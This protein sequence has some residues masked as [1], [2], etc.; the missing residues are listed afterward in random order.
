MRKILCIILLCMSAFADKSLNI[1]V[2]SMHC[3]L[4]TSLVR[5]E[6]MKVDGVISV[7][8]SLQTKTA[9]V[10]ARDDVSESALLKAIADIQYPGVIQK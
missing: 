10:V 8:V 1:F 6:L 9:V 4:C 5:K 7:K 3:P 2:E